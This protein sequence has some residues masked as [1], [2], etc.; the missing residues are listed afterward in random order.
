MAALS[1]EKT[2]YLADSYEE[3]IKYSYKGLRAQQSSS[4]QIPSTNSFVVKTEIAEE[5]ISRFNSDP[6]AQ[7]K[8]IKNE[9]LTQNNSQN[10]VP[11]KENKPKK[12][13]FTASLKLDPQKAGLQ[14]SQF[15]DEVMSHLQARTDSEINM[16]VEVEVKAPNGID[17]ETIRIVIENSAALK[18]DNPQVY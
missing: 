13:T 4:N 8:I 2:F 14:T 16:S 15:M 10:L 5:Q 9:Q 1:G 6:N 11:T 12:T 7:E 18:V 3:D 17:N